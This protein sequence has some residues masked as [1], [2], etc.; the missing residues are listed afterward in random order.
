M[1]SIGVTEF[2]NRKFVTYDFEGRW[3]ET[4]GQPERNFKMI[5]YG[6]SGNGKTDFCIKLA[7][8]LAGFTKVYYNSFEEGISKTLQDTLV[9][10]EMLE[11]KG[12]LIFGD[13]ETV[14]E[15]IERLKKRNSPQV[16]FIDSLDYINL[17]KEQYKKLIK[18]FPRKAFV[19]ISWERGG[20]PKSQ[21]AKD[22]EYMCDVKVRVNGFIAYPRCRFG[23]N[24]RFVIWDRKPKTGDQLTLTY[25]KSKTA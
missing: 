25:S 3:A 6:H 23:G 9:R 22:I 4:F 10:N 24:E 17:T 8:Y 16:V 19:V 14:D 11:V 18:L 1:G 2:M 12:K 20:K 5:V 15:M 13:K 7:K 21:Y